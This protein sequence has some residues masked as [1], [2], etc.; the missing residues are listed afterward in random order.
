MMSTKGKGKG[1]GK[2]D[3]DCKWCRLGVCWYHASPGPSRDKCKWCKQGACWTHVSL[4]YINAAKDQPPVTDAE[5]AEFLSHHTLED[6]AKTA[7]LNLDPRGQRLV[8]SKGP[9]LD[10]RDQGAV[11]I[12]RCL[13]VTDMQEGDW[14]CP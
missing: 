5:A 4:P 6:N 10:A 7:F 3:S 1:K 9:M 13:N 11:M 2:D 12:H 14:V 8:I